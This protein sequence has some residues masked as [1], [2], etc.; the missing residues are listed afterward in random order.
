MNCERRDGLENLSEQYQKL[1]LH[2]LEHS[3][4]AEPMSKGREKIVWLNLTDEVKC[5][6]AVPLGL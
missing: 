1:C 6:I 3:L 5:R 4:E 2:R